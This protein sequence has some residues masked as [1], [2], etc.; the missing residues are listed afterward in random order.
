MDQPLSA[1]EVQ[2]I[3]WSIQ[4]V[5][6]FFSVVSWSLL[7]CPD[8]RR[9]TITK[10]AA[11]K[12][13]ES[14]FGPLQHVFRWVCQST[15]PTKMQ[16]IAERVAYHIMHVFDRTVIAEAD[17]RVLH[18][19]V[20]CSTCIHVPGIGLVA[21]PIAQTPDDALAQCTLPMS[22]DGVKCLSQRIMFLFR[23]ESLLCH[24][25]LWS[26]WQSSLSLQ[27][28]CHQRIQFQRSTVN[29]KEIN[30]KATFAIQC[31]HSTKAKKK[32]KLEN[33]WF[34]LLFPT[35]FLFFFCTSLC[36]CSYDRQGVH[37]LTL[38]RVWSV[39]DLTQI[40]TH[41]HCSL[42]PSPHFLAS[43][44]INPQSANVRCLATRK[45]KQTFSWQCQCRHRCS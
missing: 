25:D 1:L 41:C 18:D 29:E 35:S 38:W 5:C 31:L 33:K 22:E 45:I 16:T 19:P 42:P 26:E 3:V 11:P 24:R 12:N 44:P 14:L 13:T 30:T 27:E 23:V 9:S 8:Q 36:C 17:A 21:R 39:M 34:P 37:F 32:A 15:K 4:S 7:A 6:L 20:N 40:S 28:L 2:V 10:E 43:L